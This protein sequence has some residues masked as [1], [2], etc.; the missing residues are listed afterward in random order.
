MG[1]TPIII[2]RASYY[3]RLGEGEYL[4]VHPHYDK[5]IV[6]KL[7]ALTANPANKDD[8]AFGT[9]VSFYKDGRRVRW[10]EFGCHVI[11]AGGDALL[12]EV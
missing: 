8:W 11:G 2:R 9:C 6:D 5:V 10:V 7:Y 1:I 12:R 3:L 4:P